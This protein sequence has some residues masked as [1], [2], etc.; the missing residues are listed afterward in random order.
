MSGLAAGLIICK[1]ARLLSRR[2]LRDSVGTNFS[3]LLGD[4][5]PVLRPLR[6]RVLRIQGEAYGADPVRQFYSKV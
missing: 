3:N 5:F 1:P 2:A 4:V 6:E